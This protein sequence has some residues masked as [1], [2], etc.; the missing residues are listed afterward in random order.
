MTPESTALAELANNARAWYD[1]NALYLND[2]LPWASSFIG[3]ANVSVQHAHGK[4]VGGLNIW[5]VY[6]EAEAEI[7]AR[8]EELMRFEAAS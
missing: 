2:G 3:L 6:N 7:K 8:A 1:G 5:E 4:V